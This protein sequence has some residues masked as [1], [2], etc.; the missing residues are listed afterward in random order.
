MSRVPRRR[1]PRAR[2]GLALGLGLDDVLNLLHLLSK[3]S[4]EDDTGAK[5]V[6]MTKWLWV[7]VEM[8]RQ[9]QRLAVEHLAFW[10]FWFLFMP[11]AT[12]I[13]VSGALAFLSTSDLIEPSGSHAK[14]DQT[15]EDQRGPG[16]TRHGGRSARAQ[17]GPRWL[18]LAI[19]TTR[20][21]KS[22]R[23]GRHCWPTDADRAR[24]PT[25]FEVLQF[26]RHGPRPPRT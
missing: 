6:R 24:R 18:G 9:M 15:S 3:A 2:L 22:R 11:S 7:K 26:Q 10:H 21:Q 16:T 14:P 4:I 19:A 1:P 20:G 5:V 25:G 13:M 23:A 8:E 17:A 12:L